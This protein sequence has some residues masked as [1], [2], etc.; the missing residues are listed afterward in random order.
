MLKKICNRIL[1][2]CCCLLLLPSLA[3]A[4]DGVF[5]AGGKYTDKYNFAKNCH[6]ATTSAAT[7]YADRELTQPIAAIPAQTFVNNGASMFNQLGT[8]ENGSPWGALYVAYILYPSGEIGEGWIDSRCVSTAYTY[9]GVHLLD[10]RLG[11]SKAFLGVTLPDSDPVWGDLTAYKQAASQSAAPQPQALTPLYAMQV[12]TGNSGR[13]HLRA[14]MSTQSK[15][16]GLYANNTNVLV[17]GEYGEWVQ[18]VVG[19]Q[20]HQGYMQ[21]KYLAPTSTDFNRI[22]EAFS[23]SGAS[24]LPDVTLYVHTG[25][26]GR[27][28]LRARPSK[29]AKSLG[30]Y[31]NGTKVTVIVVPGEN[32]GK[33][34]HV[35][36]GNQEGYM[37]GSCL[38]AD[39][40]K[41][42]TSTAPVSTQEAPAASA[43]PVISQQ[44]AQA[45][46]GTVMYV[47]TGNSGRLHLRA[48]GTSNSASL[49][50]YE[51][52]TAVT[53]L[54]YESRSW[55]RVRVGSQEGYMKL[56]F[57]SAEAH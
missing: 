6:H 41:R 13:L 4:E 52:G 1:L 10:I 27:L 54:S 20:S 8:N 47:H 2:L 23:A 11:N 3:A 51:N 34:V 57:L 26:T 29:G 19:D 5:I 36:V 42:P 30:L 21:K 44:P 28:H 17:V 22:T 55:A 50:L 12:Q 18:V 9:G 49:G 43:Q 33:F 15:S 46:Q 24:A 14:E 38:S 35:R 39:A 32:C 48:Q 16:L 37:L 7:V 25:N 53:I 45:Q 31:D 56:K 40:P